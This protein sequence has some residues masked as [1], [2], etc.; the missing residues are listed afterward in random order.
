MQNLANNVKFG[1][2]KESYMDPLNIV[3]DRNRERMNEFL[4][5]LTNVEELSTVGD[6]CLGFYLAMI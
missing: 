1:G 2:V 6:V 4:L 5:E 3:L